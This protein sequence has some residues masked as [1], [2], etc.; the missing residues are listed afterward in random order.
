MVVLTVTAGAAHLCVYKMR[1]LLA[2][3]WG[4]NVETADL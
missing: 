3:E 4:L 2:I 1:Q